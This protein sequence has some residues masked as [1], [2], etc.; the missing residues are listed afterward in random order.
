MSKQAGITIIL[1][2]VVVLGV[3]VYHF[4]GGSS[5]ESVARSQAPTT[6]AYLQVDDRCLRLAVADTPQLRQ[7][8]LSNH[9]SLDQDEGMLFVYDQSGAYGFWMKD[10]DFPIDIVWLTQEND[11]VGI[12]KEAQPSSY[13][14]TFRPEQPAKKVVETPAGFAETEN[15][16]LGDR[17]NLTPPTTTSPGGC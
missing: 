5:E 4:Y 12:T 7:Q 6:S 2:C 10:M 3:G 1:S 9:T 8:G 14:Q 13:P 11:V 17:L 16:N 15:I